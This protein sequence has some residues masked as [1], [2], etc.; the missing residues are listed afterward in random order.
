MRRHS[1]YS[2]LLGFITLKLIGHNW[3]ML[4]WKH[5]DRHLGPPS[6]SIGKPVHIVSS[7]LSCFSYFFKRREPTGWWTTQ[8]CYFSVSFRIFSSAFFVIDCHMF[9]FSRSR[10]LTLCRWNISENWLTCCLTSTL[11]P[12]EMS[13]NWWK[14]SKL[15]FWFEWKWKLCDAVEFHSDNAVKWHS[16]V[17]IWYS[18][19]LFTF[20]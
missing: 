18:D 10:S 3:A 14:F 1:G 6:R 5:V 19:A 11:Y 13:L 4:S 8:T 16:I 20:K 15:T 17:K 9:C 2:P 12:W 7:S